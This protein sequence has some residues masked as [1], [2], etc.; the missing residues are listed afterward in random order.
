MRRVLSLCAMAVLMAAAAVAG[1]A[2]ARIPFAFTAGNVAL[3]AGDYNVEPLGNTGI[4]ALTHGD[5]RI[6]VLTNPLGASL[7][8]SS[9]LVF[10]RQDSGYALSEIRMANGG[11]AG[12]LPTKKSSSYQVA[13]VLR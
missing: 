5:H 2:K 4:F 11:A 10:V 7:K 1:S 9:Q 6:L 13:V 12:T 3:E 8:D